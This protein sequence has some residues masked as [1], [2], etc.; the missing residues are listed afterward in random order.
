MRRPNA[1]ATPPG[2]LDMRR[3]APLRRRATM[4]RAFSACDEEATSKAS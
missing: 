3:A 1:L 4:S 2:T